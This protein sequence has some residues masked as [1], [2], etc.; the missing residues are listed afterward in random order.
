MRELAGRVVVVTGAASGI[1]AALAAEFAA[2]GCELALA[3]IDEI[4]VRKTARSVATP[5]RLA[6]AERVDVADEAAVRG[7]A[8]L[9]VGHFGR[10]DVVINNAGIAADSARVD[11][12][13]ASDYRT[14]MDVNFFG[15][16]HGTTAFLHHLTARPE[17]AI[18]NISSVFGVVGVPLQSPYCASKFAVR[19]FAESLRAELTV[20]APHVTP[21]VV[22][23]GG[24]ASSI[25]DNARRLGSRP[26][27]QQQADRAHFSRSLRLPP[28]VA[29]AKIR[30]AVQRGRP[31]VRIG[32]DAHVLDI[33]SRAAPT[34]STR[35]ISRTARRSGIAVGDVDEVS[36]PAVR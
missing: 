14:I 27:A 18:V 12:L 4:G 15:V 35:V 33:M 10:V 7:F 11:Q 8:D 25:V 6:L 29:A 5:E 24:I 3:D 34:L 19:G 9:V 23:P 2:A 28:A 13:A 32:V 17:A 1:G 20:V 22:H 21:I 36:A 30:R 26:A 31:R 16:V